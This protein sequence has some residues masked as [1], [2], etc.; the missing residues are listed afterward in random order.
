MNSGIGS[1]IG[2]SSL[3][4]CHS[5]LPEQVSAAT[6]YFSGRD[7]NASMD[8]EYSA[9][10]NFSIGESMGANSLTRVFEHEAMPSPNMSHR[11]LNSMP[12]WERTVR[13]RSPHHSDDDESLISKTSS[14]GG[15]LSPVQSMDGMSGDMAW[16]QQE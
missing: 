5:W 16:T 15:A 2:F 11:T 10:E 13:S 14:K 1:S 3:G 12:S 9:T 8:M 7:D 4:S 6:S